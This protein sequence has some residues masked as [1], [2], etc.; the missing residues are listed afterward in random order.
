MISSPLPL[1]GLFLTLFGFIG[2]LNLNRILLRLWLAG[3]LLLDLLAQHPL[4]RLLHD[5]EVQH[6]E[7]ICNPNF[8]AHLLTRCEEEEDG[9]VLS[10]A[11]LHVAQV[12]LENIEAL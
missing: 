9:D 12:A 11:Q 3:W 5:G 4:N 6:F 2:A 8:L 7:S 1:S 10:H